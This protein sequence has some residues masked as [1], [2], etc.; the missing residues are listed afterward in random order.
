[1]STIVT[2]Q[3]PDELARRARE[4]AAAT[5]RRL[6]DAV[7][8]WI[9]KAVSEP[10]VESLPDAELLALCDRMMDDSAQGQL[11][12]LLERLREGDI[13]PQDQQQLDRLMGSYRSGLIL[14]ARAMREA[15]ARGLRPALGNDGAIKHFD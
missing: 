2:L 10:I 4:L 6:E 1:M 5:N 8:E 14:K 15:V 9:G 12:G 3:L 7:V 11:Q 13:S